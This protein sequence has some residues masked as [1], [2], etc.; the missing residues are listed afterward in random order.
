M[1]GCD[2]Y[3]TE[4]RK[5]PWNLLTFVSGIHYNTRM[6]QN[7]FKY[8][9]VCSICDALIEITNKTNVYKPHVCCDHEATWL[10]VVDATIH[11]TTTTEEETMETTPSIADTSSQESMASFYNNYATM[12]VKDTNGNEMQY[13]SVTPYDVNVLMT[14]N[15]YYKQRFGKASSQIEDVQAII[16]DSYADSDDQET[17]RAIAEALDIKLT[18]TVEWSATMYV[19]GSMEID[20]LDDFD[21]E[22]ELSENLQVSAWN[23]DIEVEDYHVEDAREN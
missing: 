7:W 8:T 10:S 12:I 9:Y 13:K 5:I 18:K 11:P 23:G 21:L 20:L 6:T 17:L 15:H 19:S 4:D 14:D 22:S 16:L 3:H 2:V 1:W